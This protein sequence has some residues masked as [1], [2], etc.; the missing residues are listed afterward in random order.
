VRHV[1]YL[2]EL[3]RDAR[4]TIHKIIS[5]YLQHILYHPLH[6]LKHAFISGFFRI[7][8]C[9]SFRQYQN[10]STKW[11]LQLDTVTKDIFYICSFLGSETK[12][13]HKHYQC[14]ATQVA[15]TLTSIT[16]EISSLNKITYF[17]LWLYSPNVTHTSNEVILLKSLIMITQYN[18]L[19]Y[20]SRC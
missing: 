15:K 5:G 1:G 6:V 16:T 12:Q 2:Q 14:F 3:N 9:T 11:S 18:T 8:F 7:T 4:S 19:K 20:A 13:L 10:D 17:H